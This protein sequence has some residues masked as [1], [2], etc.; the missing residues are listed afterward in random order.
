MMESEIRSRIRPIAEEFIGKKG[1]KLLILGSEGRLAARQI[2][3]GADRRQ[4]TALRRSSLEQFMHTALELNPVDLAREYDL[5]FASAEA[6]G[7][8]L[9]A[10]VETA[11]TLQCKTVHIGATTMR[12]GLLLD[13]GGGGHRDKRFTDQMIQ[14]AVETGLH[15]GF[16]RPHAENVTEHAKALFEV[17]Q[18]L[19]RLTARDEVILIVAALLHDIGTFISNRSHHKHTQYLMENSDLFGLTRRERMLAALVARYHRRAHPK[20]SHRDY[21]ALPRADRMRVIKLAALLRVADAL[22][23]S[24]SRRIQNPRLKLDSDR[25]QIGVPDPHKCTGEEVALREKSDL[26]EQVYGR[27]ALLVKTRKQTPS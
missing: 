13:M 8:A 14:S 10:I 20:S 6:F 12:D 19:H 22:D 9:L 18:P 27:S 16:D 4:V 15:Y 25:L 1:V 5:P 23:R 21:T 17:M 26:F 3:P 24:H 2:Q 11:K 7:P